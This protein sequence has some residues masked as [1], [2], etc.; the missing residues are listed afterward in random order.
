MIDWLRV[1]WHFTGF[2][3]HPEA[4]AKH[5]S[6]SLL[7]SLWGNSDSSWLIGGDFNEILSLEEK[8]DGRDR[9]N[10]D[11]RDFRIVVDDCGLLDWVLKGHYLRGLTATLVQL[12]LKNVW[13]KFFVIWLGIEHRAPFLQ[14]PWCRILRF[15]DLNFLTVLK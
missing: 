6:W 1:Q 12:L 4:D 2:Y 14:D 7:R 5:L 8:R 3:G 9:S 15:D 11:I 10:S 13:T